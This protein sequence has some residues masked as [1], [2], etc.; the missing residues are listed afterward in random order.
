MSFTSLLRILLIAENQA[1]KY[2]THNDGISALEQAMAAIYKNTDA[3]GTDIALTAD[4]MLRNSLFKFSGQTSAKNITF[5]STTDGTTDTERASVTVWNA[6]TFDLTL[7]MS[8]GTGATYLLKVGHVAQIT[9]DHEDLTVASDIDTTLTLGVYDLATYVPGMPLASSLAIYFIATRT[10]KLLS[11]LPG[12]RG[13]VAVPPASTAVFTIN[14]NGSSIGTISIA[15]SGVFTFAM[16]SAQSFAPGDVLS[17]TA[18]NPADSALSDIAFTL[19]GVK[20]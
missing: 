4:D 13:V 8:T 1:D 7:K 11:G 9:L 12:S 3:D 17:I 15:T 20:T 6:G 16:A 19:E 5:P 14:K 2:A 18:P 10:F